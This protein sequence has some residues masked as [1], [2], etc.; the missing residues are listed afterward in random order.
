MLSALLVTVPLFL[1]GS[2]GLLGTGPVSTTPTVT[3]LEFD[4]ERVRYEIRNTSS[5]AFDYPVWFMDSPDTVLQTLD[6]GVWTSKPRRLCGSGANVRTIQPGQTVTT[7][8]L[9]HGADQTSRLLLSI[10][11]TTHSDWWSRIL[12]H[13]TDP[14]PWGCVVS[15]STES[16]SGTVVQ[17]DGGYARRR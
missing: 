9:V 1:M 15:N 11:P 14:T 13:E 5:T 4:G 10:R 3:L 7:T 17:T 8:A 6:E 16:L 2:R 12:G